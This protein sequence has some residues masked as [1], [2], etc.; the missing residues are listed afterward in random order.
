MRA[1]SGSEG[2]GGSF[3]LPRSPV[4]SKVEALSGLLRKA[5]LLTQSGRITAGQKEKIK[6][7]LLSSDHANRDKL[8]KAL[9]R[10]DKDTG[11]SLDL[12]LRNI[13]EK[14]NSFIGRGGFGG[15]ST[16]MMN[17]GV[18]DPA[19]AADLVADLEK[20]GIFDDLGLDPLDSPLI[21]ASTLGI[22][23]A[24]FTFGRSGGPKSSRRKKKS[25]TKKRTTTTR[26]KKTSAKKTSTQKKTKRPRSVSLK[27]ALAGAQ[28]KPK[29]QYKR[30]APRRWTAEEDQ[31]L[32]D[33]VE[34]YDG[35]NWKAIAIHVPTRTHV[36]CLQRWKK[37]LR[38]GLVKGQWSE[39][40]DQ[41]LLHLIQSDNGDP[42]WTVLARKIAGRTPKQCRERWFNHLD[43]NV[44]KGNWTEEEDTIVWNAQK[45]LGN[46]WSKIARMLNGRTENA[47][48]IRWKSLRRR[49]NGVPTPAQRKRADESARKK[50]TSSRRT[51]KTAPKKKTLD[52][53]KFNPKP[54]Q[55]DRIISR[56][57]STDRAA[58][59]SAKKHAMM[60]KK[61]V[62]RPLPGMSMNVG[63]RPTIDI[64]NVQRVSSRELYNMLTTTDAAKAGGVTPR[65][66]PGT[67]FVAA[68][69]PPQWYVVVDRRSRVRAHRH[70]S[71]RLIPFVFSHTRGTTRRNS[72]KLFNSTGGNAPHL[73]SSASSRLI[74][75]ASPMDVIGGVTR[76]LSS[77]SFPASDPSSPTD[78][79]S[80]VNAP[81]SSALRPRADT[82]DSASGVLD[83]LGSVEGGN[84]TLHLPD[85]S[86]IFS[87]MGSSGGKGRTDG[88]SNNEEKRIA[89]MVYRSSEDRKIS[90]DWT[91]EI[92]AFM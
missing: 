5:S 42:D 83:L 71:S 44:K 21:G 25:Q 89:E 56:R 40:E 3:L 50:K 24:D 29:G 8:G 6:R 43:P 63:S 47:V 31:S 77:M 80:F 90:V 30:R 45:E 11:A 60:M 62:P 33:A 12:A 39:A 37:V 88:T 70:V 14:K 67:N 58:A 53:S 26:T 32:R 78:F 27:K 18:D 46:R 82:R 73:L 20:N 36:Q 15:G 66:L 81:P 85:P 4:A 10:Y 72:A 64:S 22:G 65:T 68:P 61:I 41:L 48:K 9:S 19:A 1:N 34:K 2:G 86:E 16:D 17:F 57:S 7:T 35:K 69:D 74:R 79:R 87:T 49:F 76:T 54:L 51:Q 13:V 92:G 52:V 28:S 84:S 59:A 23:G 38:P 91:K 55:S 75:P